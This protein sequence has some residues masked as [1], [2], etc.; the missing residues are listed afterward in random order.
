MFHVHA[1]SPLH[2]GARRHGLAWLGWLALGAALAAL[3]VPIDGAVARWC[4]SLRIG[5]DVRRELEA[6]QQYGAV[7]SLVIVSAVIWSLD[8]ARRRR[9]ADLALGVLAAGVAVSLAKV[10]FGR[11]RP[12][13][14]DPLCFLGPFGQYP[15]DVRGP[16]GTTQTVLRHSWEF[17]RGIS[18]DL[19]SMPSSHTAY[20]VVLSVFLAGL[21]PRLRVLAVALA[22]LVGL[23]RVL[24]GAHYPSDVIAGAAVGLAVGTGVVHAGAGSTLLARPG[25]R[26]A[27]GSAGREAAPDVRAGARS[28]P[29]S[30]GSRPVTVAGGG[31]EASAPAMA[32]SAAGP[33]PGPR[34][35]G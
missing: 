24:F 13:H 31:A 19:W 1:W 23:C 10:L 6:L 34:A 11:P 29:A 26:R 30:P 5:G 22:C 28:A 17:W 20:A 7:S 33:A 25:R 14:S 4:R 3:L 21:Y 16:D 9:L 8:R 27:G 2:A 15:L 32:G 35:G 18:S 12:E